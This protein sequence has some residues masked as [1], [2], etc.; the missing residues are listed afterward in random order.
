[1]T[2]LHLVVVFDSQSLIFFLIPVLGL[3]DHKILTAAKVNDE[4]ILNASNFMGL[5]DDLATDKP[6]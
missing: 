2:L 3:D 5:A 1:M 4:L 6:G